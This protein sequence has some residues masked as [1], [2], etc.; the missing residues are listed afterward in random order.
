MKRFNQVCLMGIAIMAA[1][2]LAAQFIGGAQI[3]QARQAEEPAKE[4]TVE[5]AGK[6]E[7]PA[8]VNRMAAEGWELCGKAQGQSAETQYLYFQKTNQP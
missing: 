6:K 5:L 2:Y 1:L 3:S 8:T 4:F 7:V